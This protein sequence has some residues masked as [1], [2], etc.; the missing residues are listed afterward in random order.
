MILIAISEVFDIIWFFVVWNSWTGKDWSSPVWRRL[1]FLHI[2]VIILSFVNFFL[3][4]R[5][6]VLIFF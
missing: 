2:L 6:A 4:V 1:R 3:K 5:L